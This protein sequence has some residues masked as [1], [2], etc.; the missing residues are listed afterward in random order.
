M[1][2]NCLGLQYHFRVL[3]GKFKVA[4]VLWCCFLF[5]VAGRWLPTRGGVIRDAACPS[6]IPAAIEPSL[7]LW[8]LFLLLSASQMVC[9]PS[10]PEI[11][12]AHQRALAIAGLLQ[13]FHHSIISITHV[14]WPL[15]DSGLL[16]SF[17]TFFKN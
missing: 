9:P 12:K 8:T 1:R 16:F 3:Q 15:C 14:G 2:L 4:F 10:H 5:A 6:T 13:H 7:S 17:L 11:S